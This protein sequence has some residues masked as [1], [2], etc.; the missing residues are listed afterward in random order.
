MHVDEDKQPLLYLI[1][2]GIFSVI[3]VALIVAAVLSV[4]ACSV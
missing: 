1:G 3:A 2:L 4:R